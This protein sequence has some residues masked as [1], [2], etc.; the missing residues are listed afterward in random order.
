MFIGCKWVP[1]STK[2]RCLIVKKGGGGKDWAIPYTVA[3][4]FSNEF[5]R[6][7][8]H[9][10]T[11]WR[12]VQLSCRHCV[13][14]QNLSSYWNSSGALLLIITGGDRM[15]Y[16]SE[17]ITVQIRDGLPWPYTGF[18]VNGQ[19]WSF[20]GGGSC[21][22]S[23]RDVLQ[24]FVVTDIL[25]KLRAKLLIEKVTTLRRTFPRGESF[26]FALVNLN[27]SR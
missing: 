21:M 22:G 13:V 12:D 23:R 1:N 24:S 9:K 10:I 16:N 4:Y 15:H 5:G 17:V 7:E 26:R 25:F 27:A 8:N 11:K 18:Y 6:R 14:M 3:E 19:V 2:K 20:G